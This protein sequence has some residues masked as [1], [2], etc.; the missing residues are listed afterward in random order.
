MNGDE[1]RFNNDVVEFIDL[2]NILNQI[3]ESKVCFYPGRFSRQRLA[4]GDFSQALEFIADCSTMVFAESRRD[5]IAAQNIVRKH[6]QNLQVPIG[7]AGFII[8][9]EMPMTDHWTMTGPN[10]LFRVPHIDWIPPE[11]KPLE[12]RLWGDYAKLTIERARKQR[13]VH[14]LHIGITGLPAIL[15]FFNPNNIHPSRIIGTCN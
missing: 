12:R 1:N 11:A 5:K 9:L 15:Y 4:F 7:Q 6:K 14:L 3:R 10:G 13:E 8:G 2:E